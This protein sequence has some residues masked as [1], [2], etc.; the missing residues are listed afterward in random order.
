MRRF[1]HRYNQLDKWAIT[2]VMGLLV[3]LL[4]AGVSARASSPAAFLL[5][6]TGVGFDVLTA[7][8][9]ERVLN[10]ALS[11][12]P[13]I[14]RMAASTQEVLLVERHQ[15]SKDAYKTGHWPRRGDAYIY[16]YA[17]DT[18]TYALINLETGQVDA[19]QETQFVQLP[20]TEGEIARALD[21]AYAD[22]ALRTKLAALFFA[23]SGEPLRD[24]SQL[25]VKA[26]VFRADSIPE[27]LNGAARQCGLHRCAQLL[28]FTHDD[29]A[30][31]MQPIVDLSFG[32]VVQVL[33]Q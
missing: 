31:E 10:A 20:L 17:T 2:C 18:L 9:H 8:E 28:I 29:V 1:L 21:I 33:G 23:V 14:V 26:F 7:Q 13:T 4:L 30:F 32:Q 6:A 15:E 11:A 22:E 3:G 16:D 24:L 5:G 19:K 25:N 27:D 12:S